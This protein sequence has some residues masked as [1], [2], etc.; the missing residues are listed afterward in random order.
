M[1]G[2]FDR[3]MK[4]FSAS[5]GVLREDKSLAVFPLISA[6]SGLVVMATFAVPIFTW[7][8]HSESTEVYSD[9]AQGYVHSSTWH[10]DP[11][12]WFL[13]GLGYFVLIYIGIFCNAA[14]IYAANERLTGA[15]PGNLASGFRGAGAKAGAIVPWAVLSATVTLILRA[16]EER[17]GILGRIVIGIIGIAW[18]LVTYLVVPVLVLESDMSTGRAISKSATLFKQTWGENVIGNAGFGLFGFLAVIPA[19]VLFMLGAMSGTASIMILCAVLAVLWLIVTS[20]ILAALSGIYRVALYRYA[21]DGRAPSAYTMFDFN[22]AF[23]PKRSSGLFS[24]SSSRTIYRSSVPDAATARDPWKAWEPPAQ[25]PVDGAY[26]IDIPGAESFPG[27]NIPAPPSNPGE[28]GSGPRGE[29][30]WG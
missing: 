23:R 20:Q 10:M 28:F 1:S 25:E 29:S 22:E 13:L 4:L 21:V 5:W 9:L 3:S 27:Q 14:L 30:P 8:S 19:F 7:F 12:G 2:R 16:A 26:G 24:S 18:T 11:A 15:G 6:V 17:M